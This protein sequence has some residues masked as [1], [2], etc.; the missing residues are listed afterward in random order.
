MS[1]EE[2]AKI[3]NIILPASGITNLTGIKYLTAVEV[4]ICTNNSLTTLD[5]SGCTSLRDLRCSENNLR[6][7]NVSGCTALTDLVC[8]ENNLTTLDIS[9]CTAL[10]NLNCVGNNLTSLNVSGSTALTVLNCSGNNLTT[11]NISGCTALTDLSC[12]GN[13][14][15]ALN[16]SGYTALTELDCRSNDLTTLNVNGCTVLT[17]LYCGSNDLTTLNVSGYTALTTLYC[18]SNNLTT[19][20][21]S[22]CTTLIWLM[23]NNNNLTDLDLS[24]CPANIHVLCDEGVNVQRSKGGNTPSSGSLTLTVLNARGIISS[25]KES[26]SETT[27]AEANPNG[28][29]G[30]AADGNARIILRARTTQAGNVTFSTTLTG[31]TLETLTP[32]TSVP[33][34]GITATRISDGVYQASAVLVAPEAYPSNLSFPKDNFTVTATLSGTTNSVSETLSVNAAPVVLIHGLNSSVEKCYGTDGNPRAVKKALMDAGLQTFP[35]NYNGLQGPSAVIPENKYGTVIFQQVVNALNSFYEKGIACTRVDL[36]THSMGGLMARRFVVADYGNK[37]SELAYQQGMVRRVVTIATP[38]NGSPIANLAVG[39]IEGVAEALENAVLNSIYPIFYAWI[40][41]KHQDMLKYLV[42]TDLAVGSDLVNNTGYGNVPMAAVYGTVR[43]E[44]GTLANELAEIPASAVLNATKLSTFDYLTG[45]FIAAGLTNLYGTEI[46]IPLRTLFN[47]LFSGDDYDI[48]V[49]ESSAKGNIS[50][51]ATGFKGWRYMHTT[52][53]DQ[54][55]VGQTVLNLLK[56]PKTAF[57]TINSSSGGSNVRR[58]SVKNVSTA[59]V[60]TAKVEEQFSLTSSANVLNNPGSVTYTGTAD[61]AFERDV[62]MTIEEDDGIRIFKVANSGDTT[63]NVTVDFSSQD[64]GLMKLSCFSGGEGNVMYTSN[65]ETLTVKPDFSSGITDLSF[66]S[67][68]VYTNVSSDIGLSLYATTKDGGSYN[69]SAPAMGTTWTVADSTI[70]SVTEDG[71][72]RG[73]KEG[74][75]TMTA[76]L[77]GFTAT[78]SVDVGA[79]YTTSSNISNDGQNNSNN[80]SNDEANSVTSSSGGGC[81]VGLGGM[82]IL[83]LTGTL[84]FFKRK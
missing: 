34:S 38:H 25:L 7:L 43:D 2:I 21:V 74:T 56:G 68:T 42:I 82:A 48:Y 30:I 36:I 35:C 67:D 46:E 77:Q 61:K 75:T 8:D 54:E 78:V 47:A 13:N 31:A 52:I 9:G 12:V 3:D 18:E 1:S 76:T 40:H 22:K 16:V 45:G 4:L 65:V 20:N 55:D 27:V 26:I 49:G 81:N 44:L 11:L 32:G 62:Y 73:L 19:L 51:H 70:A 72:A 37:T 63:F 83:L 69:V 33:S 14:L 6:A 79:A 80:D 41:E 28:V 59:A 10:T 58:A 50:S 17:T 64:V 57:S 39:A 66:A 71:K 23:C 15:T 84:K 5:V 24:G 60:E 53:C 29:K